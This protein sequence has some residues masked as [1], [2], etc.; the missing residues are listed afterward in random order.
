MVRIKFLKKILLKKL[1][2]YFLP[3]MPY[4]F[5]SNLIQQIIYPFTE[6]SIKKNKNYSNLNL[7]EEIINS[8][9]LS[10]IKY[11]MNRTENDIKRIID[12]NKELSVG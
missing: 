11:I 3:Q 1:G 4:I 10:N 9:K 6:N 7:E 12:W 5:K 2:I 8:L